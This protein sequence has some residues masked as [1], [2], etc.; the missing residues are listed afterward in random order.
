MLSKIEKLWLSIIVIVTGLILSLYFYNVSQA[1]T[2]SNEE[3]YKV[4][5][6]YK[7]QN[8]I[9]QRTN[10]NTLGTYDYVMVGSSNLH[11]SQTVHMSFGFEIS[12]LNEEESIENS[13]V[14]P[15]DGK[16]SKYNGTPG[17]SS[18]IGAYN[19]ELDP[20]Y[21]T[22]S[23]NRVTFVVNNF[24]ASSGKDGLGSGH[25]VSAGVVV[26]GNTIYSVWTIGEDIV[27]QGI[28]NTN[29]KWNENYEAWL[30]DSENVQFA[31]GWDNVRTGTYSGNY[32]DRYTS[33][34]YNSKISGLTNKIREIA[35]QKYNGNYRDKVW[36]TKSPHKRAQL[37]E[38]DEVFS[39]GEYASSQVERCNMRY[40]YRRTVSGWG[41]GLR[42][43]CSPHYDKN[44]D[45]WDEYKT[46][47]YLQ[48]NNYHGKVMT[49]KNYNHDGTFGSM[50]NSYFKRYFVAG[51]IIQPKEPEGHKVEKNKI[52]LTKNEGNK[53]IFTGIDD[54]KLYSGN[55][56]SAPGIYTYNVDDV[57]EDGS[58]D[59][60]IGEA[61]PTTESYRNYIEEDKWYGDVE[62]EK[63]DYSYTFKGTVQAQTTYT[64]T[65]ESTITI[66]VKNPDGTDGEPKTKTVRS[67]ES[68]TYTATYYPTYDW[69]S[70][71]YDMA[72][73]RISDLDLY[74]LQSSYTLNHSTGQA[75]Y[76]LSNVNR[77]PYSVRINGKTSSNTDE[78][79]ITPSTSYST[80]SD[81]VNNTSYLSF[82]KVGQNAYQKVYTPSEAG[83]NR[84]INLGTNPSNIPSGVDGDAASRAQNFYNK[85]CNSAG[86]FEKH[87]DIFQIAGYTYLVDDANDYKKGL[88]EQCKPYIGATYEMKETAPNYEKAYANSVRTID[89]KVRNGE[90]YTDVEA[91]YRHIVTSY[92]TRELY[93][94]DIQDYNKAAIK[95]EEQWLH[96]EPV[97]VFSPVISP[98]HIDATDST[99]LVDTIGEKYGISQM[100]LDGTY[101]LQFD[102]KSYF[103]YK[104]YGNPAGFTNYVDQKYLSFPFS[105]YINNKYYEPDNTESGFGSGYTDWISVGA[106]TTSVKIYIPTW[107]EEGIYGANL[108]ALNRDDYYRVNNRPIEV[109]VEANNVPQE[110]IMSGEASHNT[111]ARSDA[112]YVATFELATQI[113]GWI[114]EFEIN[115]VYDYKNFAPS[116]WEDK[117]DV[118]IYSFTANTKDTNYKEA[119]KRVGTFNRL[120][121]KIGAQSFG[122]AERKNVRYTQDGYMTDNWMLNNTLSLARGKSYASKNGGYLVKGNTIAFTVK[123]IANLNTESDSLNIKPKY[124]YYDTKGNEVADIDVY[125]YNNDGSLIKMGSEMDQQKV[126]NISLGDFPDYIFYEDAY[127][128][129]YYDTLKTTAF[130]D[131]HDENN[132]QQVL[133]QTAPCYSVGN[134]DIN[135]NLRLITGNEE[136]LVDNL[137]WLNNSL[138][139]LYNKDGELVMAAPLRY[140]LVG[141][142]SKK[143]NLT[144]SQYGYVTGDVYDNSYDSMN[145][146]NSMQTWYGQYKIPSDILI[147]P[148]GAVE[149]YLKN[150]ADFIDGTEDFWLKDGYVVLN[151]DIKSKQDGD[152]NHLQYY[153]STDASMWGNEKGKDSDNP[154]PSVNPDTNIPEQPGDIGI[155][156]LKYNSVKQHYDI[157]ILYLN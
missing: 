6:E 81:W 63:V 144:K 21:Y 101:N 4:W 66:P 152:N 154:D 117:Y 151:F 72:F 138:E 67:N 156:P 33:L 24:L 87:N 10:P 104:G 71:T 106:Q 140:S 89:T 23:G 79:V 102:W 100:R 70:S 118:G 94:S 34:A 96:N 3:I 80:A 91:M 47:V 93:V 112:N 135:S 74:E 51:S 157:G 22:S 9:T 54:S 8:E 111:N 128:D 82:S 136:E 88:A 27:H 32:E 43:G 127:Y 1:D 92:N 129:Y 19:S 18:S 109:R 68:A 137:T 125:Y 113:S 121:S 124:R 98:I 153:S 143:F 16:Y 69:K 14:N 12:M 65:E 147:S 108:Y 13:Y 49:W 126:T 76:D 15:H 134:I 2:L 48:P 5:K 73:Y 142:Q 46:E 62:I 29:S 133:N 86:L 50:A 28:K 148:K 83:T 119:E 103:D 53:N 75:N 35:N 84:T 11:S 105:V 107:A 145:F 39:N 155:I 90:Y 40:N 131:L 20:H 42:D 95:N 64:W 31:F 139:A 116:N 26:Q 45:H 149:D 56:Y 77:V 110:L 123:T 85:L 55:M 37:A 25:N 57:R 30:K 59:F 120:G 36:T 58:K 99:Q 150:G 61:I 132:T 7:Q 122:D 60:D 146:K 130:Y 41:Y 52:I 44:N 78:Q 38:P 97:V 141:G 17:Q 114:Y 115:S